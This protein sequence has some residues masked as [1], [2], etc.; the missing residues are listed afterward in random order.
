MKW[1]PRLYAYSRCGLAK[2][3]Y[4][5]STTSEVVYVNVRYII[6]SNLLA[7]STTF[8]HCFATL[9]SKL[10]IFSYFV[11]TFVVVLP[12]CKTLHLSMLKSITHS[13][14]HVNVFDRLL[15]QLETLCKIVESKRIQCE[16]VCVD[17]RQLLK[18]W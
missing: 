10:T 4:R 8:L 12:I 17:C 15:E 16:K 1:A 5:G 13:A 3:L 18:P 14:D 6:P 11:I 9:R 2:L 7:V